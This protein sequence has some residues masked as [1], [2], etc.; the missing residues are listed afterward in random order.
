MSCTRTPTGVIHGRFQP[1]HLD[2]ITYLLAG[3]QWCDHLVVGITNPDPTLTGHDSADP[4][5]SDP[6]ANPLTY[7][8]RYQLVRAA[9][10]AAGVPESDFS[11]VPFPINNPELYHYYV[12][13]DAPFYVTIYDDWG[14][15]KVELLQSRGL[16]PVVLWE[17]P[18]DMKGITG[19]QVRT[20]MA[21]NEPWEHL[22]PHSSAELLK[23]WDIPARIRAIG[24]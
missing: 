21:R 5:R 10:C 3:K 2:H 17:R 1:L 11:L 24:A 13:M 20:L 14:R 15:R 9:L 4:L 7:F 6:A 23:K 16:Q 8:E 19:K 12:P 18:R 22:V